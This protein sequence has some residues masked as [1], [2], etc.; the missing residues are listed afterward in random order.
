MRRVRVGTSGSIPDIRHGKET[1]RLI[2]HSYVVRKVGAMDHITRTTSWEAS[3]TRAKAHACME[4]AL[5][6]SH[7]GPTR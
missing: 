1:E 5:L 2:P 3:Q 7:R 4:K 6:R